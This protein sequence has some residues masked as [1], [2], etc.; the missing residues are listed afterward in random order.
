MHKSTNVSHLPL[1]TPNHSLSKT[2]FQNL[3]AI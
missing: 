2:N 1:L 3:N